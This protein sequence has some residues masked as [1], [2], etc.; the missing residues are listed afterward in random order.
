LQSCGPFSFETLLLGC[1][2]TAIV[3]LCR[4]DAPKALTS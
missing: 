3:D 2:H 1:Y 4:G